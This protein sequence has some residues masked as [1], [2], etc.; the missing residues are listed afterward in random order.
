MSATACYIVDEK[1]VHGFMLERKKNWV[2]GNAATNGKC[3]FEMRR[4]RKCESRM[5]FVGE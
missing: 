2:F 1:Q 5:R 4:E 3:C